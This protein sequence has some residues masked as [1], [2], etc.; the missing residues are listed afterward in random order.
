MSTSKISQPG[1]LEAAANAAKAKERVGMKNRKERRDALKPIT[2]DPTADKKTRAQQ[3]RANLARRVARMA[4]RV[5]VR[6]CIA[7]WPFGFTVA[8]LGGQNLHAL[9][10]GGA[11][12]KRLPKKTAS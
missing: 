10:R 11:A 4:N 2:V 5:S 8:A 9:N 3:I 12:G 7:A 1:M 6:N